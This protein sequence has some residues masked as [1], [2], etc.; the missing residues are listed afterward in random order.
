MKTD[1]LIAMLSTNTER[2]DRKLVIRTVCIALVAGALV[3]I[4]SALVGLGPR[5]DLTRLRQIWFVPALWPA[6]PQAA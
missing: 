1:D 4:A 2:V 5:A 3:A 6:S